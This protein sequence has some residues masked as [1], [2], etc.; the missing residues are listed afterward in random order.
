MKIPYCSAEVK[1]MQTG[2]GVLTRK[3][4]ISWV[5]CVKSWNNYIPTKSTND[6]NLCSS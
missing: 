6:K 1:S 2:I 3:S 5:K 4:E